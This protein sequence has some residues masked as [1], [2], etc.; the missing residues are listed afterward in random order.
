MQH[1]CRVAYVGCAGFLARSL[2]TLFGTSASE[3]GERQS[4]SNLDMQNVSCV[5]LPR[6][7]P[8]ESFAVMVLV[9]LPIDGPPAIW[10]VGYNVGYKDNKN[11]KANPKIGL[12]V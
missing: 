3:Q 1:G 9:C 10:M 5:L 6:L 4:G 2:L 7:I 12:T 11:K 8:R